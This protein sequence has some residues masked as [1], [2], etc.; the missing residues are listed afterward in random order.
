MVDSLQV[1]SKELGG[2]KSFFLNLCYL[3][4]KHYYDICR[5]VILFFSLEGGT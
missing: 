5:W 2:K 4:F 3:L 1:I